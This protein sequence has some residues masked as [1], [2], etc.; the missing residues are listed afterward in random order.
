MKGE[1]IMLERLHMALEK[2]LLYA[3]SESAFWNDEYISKQ[4]LKADRKSV[5]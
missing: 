3:K 5:V 4:M 2:P 1:K